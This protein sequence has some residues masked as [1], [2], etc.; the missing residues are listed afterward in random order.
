MF[1]TIIILFTICCCLSNEITAKTILSQVRQ[2]VQILR[3]P[4][5]NLRQLQRDLR[6]PDG[7]I[8]RGP[9]NISRH[10]S[11]QQSS[12]ASIRPKQ[13]FGFETEMSSR[14]IAKNVRFIYH[15]SVTILCDLLHFGQL[16]QTLPTFLGNFCKGVKILHFSGE[17]VFGQLLST[18]GNFLLVTLFIRQHSLSPI[19]DAFCQQIVIFL[20]Y[21]NDSN[22]LFNINKQNFFSLL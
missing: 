8:S 9:Q 5:E 22:S 21:A 20:H 16:F 1:K 14:L 7:K 15:C 3:Q 10:Q 12:N 4:S 19:S 17:I 13:H 2:P 11:W 6:H 18:F